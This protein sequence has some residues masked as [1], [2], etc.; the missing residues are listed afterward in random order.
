MMEGQKALTDRP[1]WLLR[2][3]LWLDLEL[4]DLA[5]LNSKPQESSNPTDLRLQE[6][7][8]TTSF[9]THPDPYQLSP[10]LPSPWVNGLNHWFCKPRWI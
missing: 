1:T 8:P 6:Y 5:M 4:T 3:G 2:R 7:T 9:S 10:H